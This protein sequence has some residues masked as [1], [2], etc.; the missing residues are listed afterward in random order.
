MSD[1]SEPPGKPQIPSSEPSFG[2][3]ICDLP[4][5]DRP[6]EKLARSGAGALSD[7]ELLALFL[8]SGTQKLSAV[9]LGRKLVREAGSLQALSRKS[10]K[11]LQRINGIGPAK[12]SELTAAFEIA[13][14]LAR[15]RFTSQPIHTAK[16]LYEMLGP[17]MAQLPREE[18][19]VILLNRRGNVTANERL[20]QGSD[21]QTTAEARDI[22]SLVLRHGAPRFIL[23]HNHPSGD[24]SPSQPD[25]NV[26]RQ[27]ERTCLDLNIELLDHVIFGLPLDGREPYFSF[28]DNGLLA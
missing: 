4:D 11:D 15:E 21:N 23:A 26:T 25:R 9:E 16:D 7:A 12:A 20:T 22:L 14:R 13:A 3:R 24:P 8:R 2:G 19:R 18:L 17:A 28:R 5:D 1:V 6:R 10:L 27:V